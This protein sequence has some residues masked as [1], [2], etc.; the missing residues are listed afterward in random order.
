VAEK[1]SAF[2]VSANE[3]SGKIFSWLFPILTMMVVADVFTRYVLNSPWYFLDINVQLM[4][5]LTVMGLGY[6]Y[7]HDGH[8]LVD[9]IT[10]HLSKRKKAI[11]DIILFPLILVAIV[12]LMWQIAD[13][14]ITAIRIKQDFVASIPLPIYPYK[15]LVTLGFFL[16]LLEGVRKFIHNLRIAFRPDQEVTHG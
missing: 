10:T 5:M 9:I 16:M 12:P 4:G 15:I 8:V 1:F 14:T 6:C 11:L 7:L 2:V 3:W 13:N